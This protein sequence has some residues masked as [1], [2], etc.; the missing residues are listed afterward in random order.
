MIA[1]IA[2]PPQSPKSAASTPR[3]VPFEQKFEKIPI[4]PPASPAI[5]SVAPKTTTRPEKV[6]G[7]T[8]STVAHSPI[9]REKFTVPVAPMTEDDKLYDG[10][11]GQWDVVDTNDSVLRQKEFQIQASRKRVRPGKHDLEYDTGKVKKVRKVT[12]WFVGRLS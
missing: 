11:V 5:L 4:S 12:P 7:W 10:L 9:V 3:F 1:R 6:N 8:V 2:T